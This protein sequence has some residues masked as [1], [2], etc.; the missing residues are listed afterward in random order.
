MICI[1]LIIYQEI[2]FGVGNQG[3]PTT[4]PFRILLEKGENSF[5]PYSIYKMILKPFFNRVGSKVSLLKDIIPII[6]P[7]TTYVEPF[8]G[9]GAIFWNK[10]PAEKSVI[11][12]LDK[13]LIT[14]YKI[15]KRISPK[16]DLTFL[17]NAKQVDGKFPEVEKFIESITNNSTDG[18]KLLR[19][20]KLSNGTFNSIGI[21]HIYKNPSTESKMNN[22]SEYKKL[23]KPTTIL[24][25]DYLQ[26][27]KE[28]DSPT[29]FFFLDPPYEDTDDTYYRN[30]I[31]DYNVMNNALKNIKGKFLLTI[32]DSKLIRDTF[33][34]FKIKTIVVRNQANTGLGEETRNRKELFI[35]NYNMKSNSACGRDFSV[36]SFSKRTKGGS[37]ETDNFE[38][39]GIVSIPEFRSV[40]MTLP[41]YMYKRLPNVNGKP[42]QHKYKL[43]VPITS[44]RN[45]SSR[46]K[47]N[48]IIINQ[49]PVAKA[50]I[51][52]DKNKEKPLLDDFSPA[53]IDKLT[54]YY[55][56][57]EENEDKTPDEIQNDSYKIVPRGKPLPC[58]NASKKGQKSKKVVVEKVKEPSVPK[59]KRGRPKKAKKEVVIHDIYEETGSYEPPEEEDDTLD[60]EDED[61]LLNNYEEFKKKYGLISKKGKGLKNIVSRDNI[62]MPANKWV[63]Y[64]KSYCSK[65]NMSYRDALRDPKCKAGYKK[66][67]KGVVDELGN[68]ELLAEKYNGSQLGA[69]AGKK[70]ISL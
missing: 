13:E 34:D 30:Y 69:N 12:D 47:E 65:N 16:I 44:S 9:G 66:K 11:N 40:N 21:G 5:S 27:I 31:I 18:D 39:K 23:L 57:V 29:T 35:S 56:K 2:Y 45:I 36:S 17:D 54:D 33:K 14:G 61:L 53:D 48:S 50:I 67:G 22:I 64:V 49:K 37:V 19:I 24:N 7:H 28:Y 63:E 41:T 59:G 52:I 58:I 6:P 43:V 62:K 25:K 38:D 8:I 51:N 3:S 20:M 32:N 46:K 42:P 70:Y 60:K 15:L 1:L 10:T 4:P 26:V 68:Q 55:D